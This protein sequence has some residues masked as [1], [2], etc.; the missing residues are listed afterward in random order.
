[1]IRKPPPT[2]HLDTSFLIRA[3]VAGSDESARLRGWLSERRPLAVSTLVWA[4][5]LCGP[6]DAQSEA[7]AR[8]IAYRHV[9]VGTDEATLAATLCNDSG[10]RRGSLA[11]CVVAA[12]AIGADAPL[13]TRDEDDFRRFEAIGLRLA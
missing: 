5:L 8:R 1:M 3:L 10:R 9:P 12:T 11:D 13:A 6:L 4:E 7:I 2:V